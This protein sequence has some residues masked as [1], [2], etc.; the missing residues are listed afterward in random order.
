MQVGFIMR[1]QTD[2]STV[3][4]VRRDLPWKSSDDADQHLNQ[5]GTTNNIIP[6]ARSVK[7][8][9][10]TLVPTTEIDLA[11]SSSG[12]TELPHSQRFFSELFGKL[13][14]RP[15]MST[16]AGGVVNTAQRELEGM[17]H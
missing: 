13:K 2:S 4:R 5:P 8:N 17:I 16:T 1:R 14:I 7:T 9:P 10:N 12:E 3:V 6:P 15:R 11:P